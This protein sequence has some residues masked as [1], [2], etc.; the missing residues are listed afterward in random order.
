VPGSA[1]AS[2]ALEV[3]Q[4]RLSEKQFLSGSGVAL[5]GFARHRLAGPMS[6]QPWRTTFG[7]TG[8]L[9]TRRFGYDGKG[10]VMIRKPEDMPP[11]PSTRI[12]RA[13]R[14]P[15]GSFIGFDCEVSVIVAGTWTATVRCL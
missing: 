11:G 15:G 10:Q 12:G 9:K 2:S 14:G 13:P 3:S 8:V 6:K 7:G 1:R 5:A 4:D